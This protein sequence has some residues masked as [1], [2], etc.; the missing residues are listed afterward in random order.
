MN[1]EPFTGPGSTPS[2][3]RFWD[4]VT[5]AVIACQKVEGSNVT[6]AEHQGAGT[7]INVNRV[8]GLE[9]GPGACCYDDGTCDDLTEA[10]CNDAGGNWQGTGTTCAD[11]P[12][13]C[14]GACCEGDGGTTCVEDSTPDSCSDD[15]GTF[16]DFGSTCEGVDCTMGACCFDT[17]CD[18]ETESDCT[19]NGGVYQGGGTNC[20]SESNP[21]GAPTGSCCQPDG[22]CTIETEENCT[23]HWTEDGVCDPNTCVPYLTSCPTETSCLIEF[24]GI[25]FCECAGES[26]AQKIHVDSM[27]DMSTTLTGGAGSWTGTMGTAHYKLWTGGGVIDCSGD[28]TTEDDGTVSVHV[29]CLPGGWLITVSLTGSGIV[30]SYILFSAITSG[31]P[32]VVDNQTA[33]SGAEA[34]FNGNAALSFF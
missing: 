25:E 31:F 12:N 2:R 26:G 10:D 24:S 4:K 34:A 1:L 6:V 20:S 32:L 28:P 18:I 8:R 23:G 33:C 27:T 30:S 17:F 15:G 5:Q 21:C 13:P 14:V 16:Q 22:T 3:R 11:D 7:L 19:N 29:V 9:G